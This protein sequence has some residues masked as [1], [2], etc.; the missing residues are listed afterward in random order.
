MIYNPF[1]LP[2]T[3]D[4]TIDEEIKTLIIEYINKEEL[5]FH[6]ILNYIEQ[7]IENNDIIRTKIAMYYC[8]NVLINNKNYNENEKIEIIRGLIDSVKNLEEKLEKIR[9]N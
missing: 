1:D 4:K 7:S 3:I 2:S 5:T 6:T 8:T 9:K